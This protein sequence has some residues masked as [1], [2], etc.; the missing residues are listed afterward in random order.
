MTDEKSIIF[1]AGNSKGNIP[2]EYGLDLLGP[3]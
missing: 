1:F 2:R 3:G